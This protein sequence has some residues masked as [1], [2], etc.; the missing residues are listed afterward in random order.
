MKAITIWQPWA[1][2]IL[3]RAKPYEFRGWPAPRALVGQ[4]IA[5]HAGARKV[6]VDEIR[7]L[8]SRLLGDEQ[9]TVALK[10]DI[11]RPLLEKWLTAP[12]MLPLSSVLCTAILGAPVRASKITAEFGGN[13]SDRDE[14]CNFAWPLSSLEP[15]HPFAPARGMQGF[16]DWS[17]GAEARE[18]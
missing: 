7:Y 18:K 14:H 3:A 8:L 16:W 2:L 10:P 12:Q 15:I 13:D 9:W 11:A 17:P 4:R 6:R 5:I 1:S